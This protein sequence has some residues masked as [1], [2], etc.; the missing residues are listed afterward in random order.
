MSDAVNIGLGYVCVRNGIEDE[1]N[2][3]AR[4][5]EVDLF[6]YHPLLSKIDKSMVGIPVLAKKL[7]QI[8][9]RSI[10]ECLPAIVNNIE[11]TLSKREYELAQLPSHICSG[12]MEANREFIKLLSTM[13]ESLNR[14]LVHGDCQQYPDDAQMHCTARLREMFE[15]YYTDLQKIGSVEKGFLVKEVNMLE[16]A[17]GAGL[18][19]FLSRPVFLNLLQML[20][21]EVSERS[22]RLAS[23]VWDYVE[24]VILRIIDLHCQCYPQLH[25]ATR[26][27][28]QALILQKRNE[29]VE[30]VKEMIEMEKSVDF[31]LS[32]ANI[33]T[34]DNFL[35]SKEEFMR[36][37]QKL[38]D[39][40]NRLR[41]D[42]EIWNCDSYHSKLKKIVTIDGIG[43]LDVSEA[44]EMNSNRV[45]EAYVMKMTVMAYWQV[46]LMRLGDGIPLHLQ[47]VYRNLIKK[48]MDAEIL[49]Q[50]GGP[51]LDSMEKF[52]E[53]SPE[54]AHKRKSLTSSVALLRD[55]KKTVANI[56][57]RI[58]ET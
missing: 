36:G 42:W 51:R 44:M 34:F 17:K 28:A 37:F 38:V 39:E 31:T 1:S 6:A 41:K 57:D 50:V 24:K 40:D 23:Q 12:P 10:S 22:L 43:E 3:E 26:R 53:E 25:V 48:E 58:A 35:N 7:M 4:K 2:E 55:S 21:D 18:P 33:Q 9:A 19:N 20:V 47:F 27:L 46:V 16:E 30:H 52:L 29:C 15:C 56:M 14:L 5:K 13:K 8:Q 11:T 49:K 45:Q 32:P 54:V